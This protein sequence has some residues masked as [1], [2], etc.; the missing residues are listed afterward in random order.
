[1]R[2]STM[3]EIRSGMRKYAPAVVRIALSL[4]FLYFGISQLIRPETFTGWLPAW[5]AFIPVQARTLVVLNGAFE[6]IAGSALLIGIYTRIASL[7]LG[8][9]LLGITMSIGFTEIGVRDFGLAFATLAIALQGKDI[10]CL[11][12]FI[13]K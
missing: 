7:L 4:V 11:E 10:L 6:V 12:T 13:K 5:T 1:M 8:L 2:L 9:H 3:T